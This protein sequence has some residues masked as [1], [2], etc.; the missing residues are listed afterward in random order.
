VTGA[1]PFPDYREVFQRQRVSL[2][3]RVHGWEQEAEEALQEAGRLVPASKYAARVPADDQRR[4]VL[5]A[6]ANRLRQAADDVRLILEA[7]RPSVL[8][9]PLAR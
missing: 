4:E 3:Q 7:P 6:E 8:R 1:G 9:D 2:L 5:L